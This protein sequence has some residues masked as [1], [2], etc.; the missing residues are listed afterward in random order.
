[1]SLRFISSPQTFDAFPNLLCGLPVLMYDFSTYSPEADGTDSTFSIPPAEK[2]V[3][4]CH[5]QAKNPKLYSS[6]LV[7]SVYGQVARNQSHVA[8][9]KQRYL[10]LCLTSHLHRL[11]DTVESTFF[12]WIPC[13]ILQMLLFFKSMHSIKFLVSGDMTFGRL[14]R[15]PF[16]QNHFLSRMWIIMSDTTGCPKSSFL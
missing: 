5:E 4:C 11:P 9:N 3:P 16:N 14:D 7:Q 6:R 13:N 10:R 8:R 12:D 15:L 2:M 1:M